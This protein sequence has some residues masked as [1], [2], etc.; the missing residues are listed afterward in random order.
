[1]SVNLPPDVVDKLS[2]HESG[3]PQS[4]AIII[5]ACIAVVAALIALGGVRWQIRS[6]ATEARKNRIADNRLARQAQL[7]ERMADGF[8]LTRSLQDLLAANTRAPIGGW[9][10]SDQNAFNEQTQQARTLVSMLRVLGAHSSSGAL[11][12]VT[13]QLNV[14]SRDNERGSPTRTGPAFLLDGKSPSQLVSDMNAAFESDLSA[15]TEPA[16]S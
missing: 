11:W 13:Y 2:P 1:V 15:Q 7:V 4:W 10:E 5:A 3:L 8:A 12:K 6:A 14:T 9:S 16:N